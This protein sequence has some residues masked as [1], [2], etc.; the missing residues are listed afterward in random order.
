MVDDA[1]RGVWLH[2]MKD[3]SEVGT[4]L[5]GFASM[6]QNQFGKQVKVVRTY[7]GSKFKSRSMKIFYHEKVIIQKTSCVDT[8]Q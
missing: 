1:S 6:A 3:K 7:N 5:K 8:P 4:L 2:L